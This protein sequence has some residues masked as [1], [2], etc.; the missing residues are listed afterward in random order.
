M[1]RGLQALADAAA[2]VAVECEQM[3]LQPGVGAQLLEQRHRQQPG[4]M[5]AEPVGQE[6]DPQRPLRTRRRRR[7]PRGRGG[8]HLR[9]LAGA[10]QLLGGAG[11]LAEEGE[12]LHRRIAL[13]H[14]AADLLRQRLQ[15]APVA[16]SPLPVQALRG[17]IGFVRE[18]RMRTAVGIGG[19]LGL[20]G[21]L[22]RMAQPQ[23]DAGVLGDL[24][25]GVAQ[26]VGGLLVA[27]LHPARTSQ[28]RQCFRVVAAQL[29]RPL[30]GPFAGIQVAC[31]QLGVGQHHP[32]DEVGGLAL[33][34][35]AQVLAFVVRDIHALAGP[36]CDV[37]I[38]RA[39]PCICRG[40]GPRRRRARLRCLRTGAPVHPPGARAAGGRPGRP[41]RLRSR[42]AGRTGSGPR[43]GGR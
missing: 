3:H 22:Q 29:Q 10:G 12:R 30:R 7:Q 8:D 13:R 41:G 19:G 6:A 20:A 27:A 28:P 37:P 36:S 26:Q 31:A 25:R 5:G 24:S 11:V 1:R 17:H 38:V 43:P 18:Q 2:V 33:H 23:R 34:R 14:R 15:P 39:L 4:G 32:G 9:T 35:G 16:Q 21:I 42:W 40:P